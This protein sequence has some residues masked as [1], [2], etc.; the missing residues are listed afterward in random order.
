MTLHRL[1]SSLFVHVFLKKREALSSRKEKTV[2]DWF[3]QAQCRSVT[4]EV[5]SCCFP[6][7]DKCPCAAAALCVGLQA[8]TNVSSRVKCHG[9]SFC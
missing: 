4:A 8:Q 1:S 2:P 6:G 5:P 9:S 3:K 7:V